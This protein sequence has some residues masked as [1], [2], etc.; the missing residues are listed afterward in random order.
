MYPRQS[1][2]MER[3]QGIGGFFF[4]AN[5]QQR[6]I[7][8]YR[9]NLGIET[10]NPTGAGGIWMQEAG[11]TVFSPFPADT[12]YFGRPEQTYMLN[13]RV[14]NLDAMLAQLRAAGATLDDRV[15]LLDGIGRFSWVTD[16]EGNRIELWEPAAS[17]DPSAAG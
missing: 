11:P 3:V 15:E 4:R 14:S 10:M 1:V 17:A 16:P 7:D 5:D 2:R 6:L 13:L 9:D 8:W 12:D